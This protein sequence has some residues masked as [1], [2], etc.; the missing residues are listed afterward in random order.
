MK[1]SNGFAIPVDGKIADADALDVIVLAASYELPSKQKESLLNV[2]KRHA[3]HGAMIWGID[4]GVMFLAEAGLIG[5]RRATAHRE[6]IPAFHE[7]W[8][9][10]QISEELFVAD[11]KLMTCGG[12]TASLDMT[13][14]YIASHFGE[15]LAL[16]VSDEMLLSMVRSPESP[17]LRINVF[18]P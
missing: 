10:L 2:V 15:S 16:A 4:Q 17:L 6:Q 7:H 12:H 3:R 11:G 5:E 8:P 13:L 18:E 9:D 1:T 14:S